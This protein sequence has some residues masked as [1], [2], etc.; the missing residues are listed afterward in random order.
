MFTDAPSQALSRL[1]LRERRDPTLALCLSHRPST[2]IDDLSDD[3]S[4]VFGRA[5]EKVK[6]TPFWRI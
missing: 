5:S 1:G 2:Q 6:W 3:R 4:A